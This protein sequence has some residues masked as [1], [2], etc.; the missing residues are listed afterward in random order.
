MSINKHLFEEGAWHGTVQFS[1]LADHQKDLGTL[2]NMI[3][4]GP[5]ESS[6]MFHVNWVANTFPV[7]Q[8]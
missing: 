8:V 2:N 5:P 1:I 3:V 4:K 6:Q 7:K